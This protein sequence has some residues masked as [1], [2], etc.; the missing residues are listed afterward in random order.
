M[1]LPRRVSRAAQPGSRG[2]PRLTTRS[3]WLGALTALV[4]VAA[5]TG[6][7][8]ARSPAGTPARTYGGLPSWLPTA[9]V[10]VNRIVQASPA[11]PWLAIEGDTVHVVLPGGQVMA[12]AVGPSV[13]EEGQFPVPATTL[14]SFTLTLANT[15]GVI[16]LSSGA[17]TI[18]DEQGQL[19]SPKVTAQN[20]SPAPA[21]AVHGKTVT[22]TLTAV[23]PTGS[24]E[25]MWA[26]RGGSP[27]VSWD[28]D[29]EID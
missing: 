8:L 6:L 27:V 17:F 18:R 21:V 14:C 24:G 2:T 28:F 5:V 9:S 11:H 20:G 19:H 23:L 15:S 4:A 22:L 7:Y 13:P 1:A 16:P 10:P 26:P 12:T 29:G 3:A 25:L